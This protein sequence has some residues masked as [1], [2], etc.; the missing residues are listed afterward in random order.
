MVNFYSRLWYYC[1][2]T[3]NHRQIGGD[4]SRNGG[5]N[6]D[7]TDDLTD[8]NRTL[9]QLSY[10]PI[11]EQGACPAPMIIHIFGKNATL[12]SFADYVVAYDLE[13]GGVLTLTDANIDLSKVDVTKAGTY[14]VTITVKDS[15][16]KESSYTFEIVILDEADTEAPVI[17]VENDNITMILQTFREGNI[18]YSYET[19]LCSWLNVCVLSDMILK[20]L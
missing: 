2:Q 16:D 14:P 10:R 19:A 11:L 18:F 8:A 1:G 3:K 20:M 5:P 9:S 15:G 7:R 6:R 13:D 12:P 4:F 17:T